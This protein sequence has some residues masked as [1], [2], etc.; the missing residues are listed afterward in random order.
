MS[1]RK[2]V[3]RAKI[4]V[5]SLLPAVIL[6]SLVEGSAQIYWKYREAVSLNSVAENGERILRNDAINFIKEP[7]GILGYRLRANLEGRTNSRGLSQLEEIDYA[8]RDSSLRIVSVGE[9]TT[10]GTTLSDNYPTQLHSLLQSHT[11]DYPGGVE[12]VN[13]GVS[14]WVSGQWTLYSESELHQYKPDIVILYAGWNDFQSYSPLAPPPS[15]SYFTAAYQ[16][17][18]GLPIGSGLKSVVLANA[19]IESLKSRMAHR[20]LRPAVAQWTSFSEG[21]MITNETPLSDIVAADFAPNSYVSV[22]VDHQLLR[23]ESSKAYEAS[24]EIRGHG[25]TFIRVQGSANGRNQHYVDC[26]L[27]I[28]EAWSKT[29]CK[30]TKPDDSLGIQVSLFSGEAGGEIEIRGFK[31]LQYRSD[32]EPH[33][34]A[35]TAGHSDV[36]VE[37]TYRFYLENLSRTVRAFKDAN[38]E[39]NIAI[40]SLVGR[41]PMDTEEQFRNPFGHVWWM[42]ENVSR[43]EASVLLEEFN[44]LIERYAAE[45]GLLFVDMSATFRELDRQQLMVD[46]AHMRGDGYPIMAH[47]FYHQ[48]REA[49]FL[50][51]LEN[52]ELDIM[53]ERHRIDP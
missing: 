27:Q 46:F 39:V 47:K 9:S 25:A 26:P 53:M 21:A 43:E 19:F 14:G 5:F 23:T 7:D 29:T 28:R 10:Q 44:S 13:A 36:P 31:L 40:S 3:S 17:T 4:V 51:G 8:R 45:N 50:T 30:F 34:V 12:V 18:R 20:V 1:H 32:S 6:F 24:I 11:T 48:F 42:D 37:K 22:L 16:P 35:R 2:I 38:P 41:W 49:G 33:V 52:S 15:Q